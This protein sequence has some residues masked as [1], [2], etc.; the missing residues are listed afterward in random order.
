MTLSDQ[1]PYSVGV[2]VALQPDLHCVLAPNPSPMTY[3]GTNTY[4]LGQDTLAV[5]DP[6]P[7]IQSHL[8]ALIAAIAGR[9]VT[10]ILLT[11]SHLDHSP[12]ARP[13]AERVNAPILAFGNSLAGRSAVMAELA[14]DGLVGGGEGIDHD[15][16]PDTRVKDGQQL[17]G[18][19][20][21][22]RV[23]HTPGHIGN[24]VCFQWQ[25]D[26]FTGDHV[27]GWASSLVSPPDGDLTDFMASCGRLKGI[28]ARRYYPAHGAPITDPSTRLDWL[29]THRMSRETQIIETLVKTPK[30]V[31]DLTREIYTD[32]TPAL[33]PAAERNVFAHL[34]DLFGRGI[35]EATPQL[36]VNA[37][38]RLP[39]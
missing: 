23:L 36:S 26:I 27:M 30:T 38:F 19:W 13:L 18:A 14:A 28:N 15:F 3:W 37:N 10:H 11:H 2:P 16:Q 4:L 20:G 7:M 25:D 31:P 9:P 1:Q 35:V 33:L 8:D 24:H 29:I 5:I 6:G 12:M 21:E 22:I 39:A 32:V 34:V 17:V